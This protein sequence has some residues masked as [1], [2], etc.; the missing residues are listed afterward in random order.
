MWCEEVIKLCRCLNT[1]S[2]VSQHKLSYNCKSYSMCTK[3]HRSYYLKTS[4]SIHYWVL[5]FFTRNICTQKW[6]FIGGGFFFF[7]YSLGFFN[8]FPYF[9]IIRFIIFIFGDR[10]CNVWMYIG[11]GFNTMDIEVTIILSAWWQSVSC[12]KLSSDCGL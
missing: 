3:V 9:F 2:F 5:N 10:H 4:Y 7:Y 12:L 6:D 8:S 1:N 11:V